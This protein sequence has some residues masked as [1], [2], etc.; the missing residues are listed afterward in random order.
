MLFHCGGIVIYGFLIFFY[1][2][3]IST[4]GNTP[5]LIYFCIYKFITLFRSIINQSYLRLNHSP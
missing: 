1:G 3:T 4:V 5:Q 2:W